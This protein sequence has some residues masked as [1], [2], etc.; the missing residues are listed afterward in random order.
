MDGNP[1]HIIATPHSLRL[2][3]YPQE[4]LRIIGTSEFRN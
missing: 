3:S 2:K 4:Q 1:E